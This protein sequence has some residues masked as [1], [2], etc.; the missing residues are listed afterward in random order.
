MVKTWLKQL[1][2][3][4]GFLVHSIVNLSFLEYRNMILEAND[5]MILGNSYDI[6]TD[7]SSF[8]QFTHDDDGMIQ[9]S[10]LSVDFSNRQVIGLEKWTN[11]ENTVVSSLKSLE[12]D[13]ISSIL[14]NFPISVIKNY[15]V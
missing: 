8:Y 1:S 2:Y 12:D 7:V 5:R 15:L 14:D 3:I 4:P 9:K 10:N 13:M 11:G 6:E